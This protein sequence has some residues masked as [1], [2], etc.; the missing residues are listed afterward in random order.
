MGVIFWKKQ[1]SWTYSGN[2]SGGP[3]TG[4]YT[5]KRVAKAPAG[6]NLIMPF[7]AAPGVTRL[8]VLI[9]IGPSDD[10]TVNPQPKL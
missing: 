1:F 10:S 7:D 4:T 3:Q 6:A 9:Q 8:S 5:E 2:P